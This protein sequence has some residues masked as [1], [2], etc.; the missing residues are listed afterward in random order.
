MSLLFSLQ[1]SVSTLLNKRSHCLARASSNHG[2][3]NSLAC[4]SQ[5][6]ETQSVASSDTL[7]VAVVVMSV[8]ESEPAVWVAKA[9][10]CQLPCSWKHRFSG[11][12]ASSQG[13]MRTRLPL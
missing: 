1:N 10:D 9:C 6:V 8:S 11:A 2:C 13:L 7:T 3:C 4:Q 5:T 12:W